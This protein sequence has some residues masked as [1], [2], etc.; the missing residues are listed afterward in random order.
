[1]SVGLAEILAGVTGLG[2]VA[3]QGMNILQTM[4]NWNRYNERSAD[5]LFAQLRNQFI[6]Q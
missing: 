1:M 5:P 2:N 3:G 6:G 4:E